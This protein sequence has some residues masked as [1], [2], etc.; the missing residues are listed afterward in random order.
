MKKKYLLSLDDES[1][2]NELVMINHYHVVITDAFRKICEEKP[3]YLNFIHDTTNSLK[4]DIVILGFFKK[5]LM[6]D[7]EFYKIEQ[8]NN[9]NETL[10]KTI[11][12]LIDNN[13]A[14]LISCR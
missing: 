4:S 2:P 5:I 6:P 9:Y 1:F 11:Q 14:A 3:E 10:Q 12:L 8:H 7:S 13:Y